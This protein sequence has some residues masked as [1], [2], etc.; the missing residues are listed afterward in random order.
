[1]TA[2]C[3]KAVGTPRVTVL[4]PVL[5]A[6]PFLPEAIES[7]LSQTYQQ[8]SSFGFRRRFHGWLDWLCRIPGRSA[9]SPHSRP[10]SLWVGRCVES[11]PR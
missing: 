8:N 2:L 7:V 10:G 6:M 4:M 3:D 9:G 5:N 11:W 1:M